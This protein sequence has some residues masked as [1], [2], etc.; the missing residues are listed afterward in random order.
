MDPNVDGIRQVEDDLQK[1]NFRFF[2]F[3]V[4]LLLGSFIMMVSLQVF[5][6]CLLRNTC[7]TYISIKILE[8]RE[9]KLS[10]HSGVIG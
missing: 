5:H 3:F 1:Y 4:L 8:K 9:T 10:M 7:L 2:C 6:I